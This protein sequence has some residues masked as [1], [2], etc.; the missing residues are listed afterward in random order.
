VQV[1]IV[2]AVD[3]KENPEKIE[4][5]VFPA[6]EVRRRFDAAYTARTGAGHTVREDFGMW[7]LLDP[8]SRANTPGHSPGY[9]GS[10][11]IAQH[12]R[13]AMYSIESLLADERAEPDTDTQPQQVEVLRGVE[14]R[15]EEP[16]RPLTIAGVM[17]WA[18][19]RVAEIAGVRV[20]AVKLDLKLEY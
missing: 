20:E 19:E 16:Q 17:A 6:D 12:P 13:V 2:A 8:D 11:I 9:V 7:V 15:P 14:A 10:G 3:S 18:R 1:V 5:Y 4:V